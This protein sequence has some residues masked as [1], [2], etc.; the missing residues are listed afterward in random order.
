MTP[1]IVERSALVGML[2]SQP[3]VS[4]SAVSARLAIL[5]SAFAF[6]DGL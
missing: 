5:A 2:R 6:G 3:E 1:G 4:R